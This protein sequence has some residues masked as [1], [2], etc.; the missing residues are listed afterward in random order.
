MSIASQRGID[1]E[2]FLAPRPDKK[3]GQ[4]TSEN[5]FNVC[6]PDLFL[7]QMLA[8]PSDSVIH[9]AP[10]IYEVWPYHTEND[11]SRVWQP[12]AGWKML[13]QGATLKAIEHRA[14]SVVIGC[15]YN[16]QAHGLEIEGLTIDCNLPADKP[17][18]CGGVSVQGSHTRIRRVKVVNFGTHN[19]TECFAIAST[20]GHEEFGPEQDLLIEDCVVEKP[21]NTSAGGGITAIMITGLGDGARISGCSVSGKRINNALTIDRMT[22]SVIEGNIVNGASRGVYNDT[23]DIPDLIVQNNRFTDVFFG[24]QVNFTNSPPTMYRVGELTVRDNTVILSKQDG[25]GG[26]VLHGFTSAPPY[27]FERVLIERNRITPTTPKQASIVTRGCRR[28]MVRHNVVGGGIFNE[29]YEKAVVES[30]FDSE[31]NPL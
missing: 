4:G 1:R 11:R 19:E 12:K 10:A 2:I 24:L 20:G 16:R 28:I 18:M 22:G 15:D 3:S 29:L 21:S 8:I 6:S 31:L 25:A 23:W 9:F 13:G 5:P 14:N 7:K 30:N 27:S 26:I 17:V